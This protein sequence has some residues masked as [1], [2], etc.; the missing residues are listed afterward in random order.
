MGCPGQDRAASYAAR[1]RTTR[2]R[3]RARSIHPEPDP[4]NAGTEHL[5]LSVI[6]AHIAGMSG[7]H[8][9]AMKARYSAIRSPGPLNGQSLKACLLRQVAGVEEGSVIERV[10]LSTRTELVVLV[11]ALRVPCS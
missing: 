6:I 5:T 7:R 9:R 1:G 3:I 10:W 8:C 4:P 11:P 2:C